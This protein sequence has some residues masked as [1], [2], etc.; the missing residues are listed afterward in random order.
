MRHSLRRL[1]RGWRSGELLILALA[2]AI[3]VAAA[4]AV[5]VFSARV[6]T[7]IEA[8]S[9]EALGADLLVSSRSPIPAQFRELAQ[10]QGL[11]QTE[12]IHLPTM[13]WRGDHSALAGLKA[14]DSDYPLRGSLRTA[15]EPYTQEQDST[16]IPA[17]GTA[18]I[19][20]RLWTELRLESDRTIQVGALEL[21]VDRLLTYEPDRGA[22]FVDL[23]PR[24]LIN[25]ADLQGSQLLVPGSR[26]QYSLM[27]AGERDALRSIRALTAPPG[28]TVRGPQDAR[29]ELKRALERA[30]SFLDL[31]AIAASLLAAAAIALCARQHGLRLRDEVALLRCLGAQR[32]AVLGSIV[33]TLLFIGLTAG[34]AGALLGYGAQA[35]LATLA[36]SF[37]A[38]QLPPAPLAPAGIALGLGFLLMLGFALPAVLEARDTPPIRI[39]QRSASPASRKSMGSFAAGVATLGALVWQTGDP[40][41]AILALGGMLAAAAI[42]AI[43]AWG[44]VLALTPLRKRAGSAWRLGL[45]NVAR[46]RGATV[47]QTVALGLGLLALL[48][49]GVV[50]GDLLSTWRGRLPADTPNQFLINIQQDQIAPLQT[51]LDERQVAQTRMWPMARARLIKLNDAAVHGDLFDDP[52]TQRWV[53]REFNLS[54]SAELQ[55]GNEIYAGQWWGVEG[56]GK[57]WLSADEYAQQ[58]LDLKLGDRLTLLFG[59]QE[60]ELTVHNFRSVDWETFQP[61]FF[62]MTPPGVLDAMPATWLTS[63][64][65]P[66]DKRPVLRELVQQFPN[67]TALDIEAMMN[68]VRIIM[69]R[70]T[71]ALQFVFLFTIA[72]GLTVLLAAIE[73]TRDERVREVGLLRALGASRRQIGQSL[74]A[75]YATLGLLAGGVAALAAQL[76]AWV[77]ASAVLD[78][79]YGPRPILFVIGAGGGA[80]F[81]AAL[82][83]LALYRVIGTPPQQ[84]LRRAH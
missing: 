28:V 52:E 14:V 59:S 40:K 15:L 33:G 38:T 4:A 31:A 71:Q 10:V 49:L 62:L 37:L 18:W 13:V 57:A 78:I 1:R 24:V 76:I 2:L 69:D 54:W 63:F 77:L 55:S 41:F 21:R 84:V 75:E 17:P 34:G 48:L 32:N 30:Q 27:L 19:D 44:L 79:P 36:K 50:H 74:L 11:A 22:G 56:T 61:N 66:S 64:Y 16:S 72:A 68:Q 46:R 45:G 60:V 51:F 47:A 53:N 7:A 67:V 6:W 9:G 81:V 25:R 70:I 29:P 65:L 12:T 3:S 26:A 82:G 43:L 23:A 20:A 39:F 83:W 73:A 80:V 5:G 35:I 8:Q 42:L 58:R